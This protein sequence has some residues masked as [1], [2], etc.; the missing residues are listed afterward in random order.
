MTGLIPQDLTDDR[1]AIPT[2]TSQFHSLDDVAWYGSAYTISRYAGSA[3]GY[4][5]DSQ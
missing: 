4:S 5:V 2:I 1:Q 3:A